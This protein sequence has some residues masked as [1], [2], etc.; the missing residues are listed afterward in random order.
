MDGQKAD[1]KFSS[2][3]HCIPNCFLNIVILIIQKYALT[4]LNKLL[5]K[6]VTASQ[7]KA[8]ANL[9]ERNLVP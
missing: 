6:F 9:K 5:C 7:L 3:R 4:L 1:F 8:Q 2:A